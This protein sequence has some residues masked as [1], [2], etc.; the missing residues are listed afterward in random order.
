MQPGSNLIPS[1]RAALIGRTAQRC[2]ESGLS[3][4]CQ[5]DTASL[6]LFTSGAAGL[7]TQFTA[8]ERFWGESEESILSILQL[9]FCIEIC[10]HLK[11]KW[12]RDKNCQVRHPRL[13]YFIDIRCQTHLT[14]SVS[15]RLWR[16]TLVDF[17]FLRSAV[18]KPTRFTFHARTALNLTLGR[19]QQKPGAGVSV[20]PPGGLQMYGLSCRLSLW[21]QLVGAPWPA[22]VRPGAVRAAVEWGR[23]RSHT[24]AAYSLRNHS[25]CLHFTPFVEDHPFWCG[26]LIEISSRHLW[27]YR[28]SGSI[29]FNFSNQK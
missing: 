8:T 1:F 9:R 7:D 27:L 25:L 26:N 3:I 10:S 5:W 6:A 18:A 11:F 12:C 19:L 21:W 17:A 4:W 13:T 2:S 23:M 16:A 22:L 24:P 15:K 28:Y 14:D 20:E 29:D